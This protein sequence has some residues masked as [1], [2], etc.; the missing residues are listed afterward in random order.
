[1]FLGYPWVTIAATA[2]AALLLSGLAQAIVSVYFSPLSQ[3]PG[4]KFAA[5]SVWYRAYLE[6]FKGVNWTD[7]LAKLHSIYGI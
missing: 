2:L 6:A 3:V 7:N 4:P 1:M 5:A